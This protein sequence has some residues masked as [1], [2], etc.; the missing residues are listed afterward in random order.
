MIPYQELD[1]A[2]ARWKGRTEGG[3][4]LP[5]ELSRDFDDAA[6][7]VST[8]PIPSEA[9]GNVSADHTSE[10]ELGEDI[11]ETYEDEDR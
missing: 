7:V 6:T 8:M 4:D 9:I 1:R 3:G 5:R 10:I 11:V 2:L